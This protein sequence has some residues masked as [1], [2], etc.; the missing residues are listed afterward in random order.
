MKTGQRLL[1]QIGGKYA[2]TFRAWLITLPLSVLISSVYATPPTLADVAKWTGALITIHAALGLLMLIAG[3]TVL[4]SRPR[5]SRPKTAIAFFAMLGLAR[6][7]LLQL[8]QGHLGIGIFDISERLLFNI[9]ASVVAF[10]AIAIVIDNFTADSVVTRNL[11]AARESLERLRETERSSLLTI[12]RQILADVEARVLQE[13]RAQEVD[14]QRIRQISDSIV[15]E[16]SHEL[17]RPS[18]DDDFGDSIPES[19]PVWRSVAL[20]T[21][22]MRV[23]SPL[24]VVGIYQ[25]LVFGTVVARLN[26]G[27]AT[28]NVLGALPTFFG[29]W[30]M[31]RYVSLPRNGLA[32]IAVLIGGFAAVGLIAAAINAWMWRTHFQS[33]SVSISAVATGVVALGLL[34]SL[35]NAVNEGRED[36]R[37]QLGATLTEQAQEVARLQQLVQERRKSAARFLH[38]TVQNQ[39]IVSAMSGESS[40]Q[41][42]HTLS[43]LFTGYSAP[44]AHADA[45]TELEG[46][47]NS[48]SAVLTI[49]ARIDDGVWEL[50]EGDRHLQGL[51]ADVVAEGLT[52]AVKHSSGRAIEIVVGTD[53]D[54]VKATITTEGF[55]SH[56]TTRGIGLQD[57][58]A[59]GAEV[60]L[61]RDTRGST[62][63]ALL[64]AS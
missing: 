6:A 15:R 43:N 46:L 11:L 44:P 39:L 13:L 26:L 51:L 60:E 53:N 32:R 22:R 50:L 38:G 40:E 31:R 28:I 4:S 34:L 19:V 42:Q 27:F 18:D 20:T 5:Q 54:A 24:A 17:S 37:R 49:D 3:A 30:L 56:S 21:D 8:A 62:L 10:S 55:G 57:L 61:V 14:S 47:L 36:R 25:G 35:G 23:P 7:V 2:I 16:L 58:Q 12:D 29:L 41:I 52:N 48:W 33:D 63:V 1:D 64:T 59:R 9:V 45:R